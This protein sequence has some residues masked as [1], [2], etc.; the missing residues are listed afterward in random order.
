MHHATLTTDTEGE[1]V[2][3]AGRCLGSELGVQQH[4][5]AGLGGGK[6]SALEVDRVDIER[7]VIRE[8][9]DARG[10]LLA[11]SQVETDVLDGANPRD[12]H[13]GH[14]F[15]SAGRREGNAVDS[16]REIGEKKAAVGRLKRCGQVVVAVLKGYEAHD[17][18]RHQHDKRDELSLVG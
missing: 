5:V 3:D 14:L 10:A 17:P 12:G 4:F 18:Q 9:D 1:L 16:H 7:P 15:D 11:A 2:V 8:R 13:T 6:A